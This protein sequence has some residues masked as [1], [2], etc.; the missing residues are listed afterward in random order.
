MERMGCRLGT[1][2]RRCRGFELGCE[3]W[4]RIPAAPVI[5]AHAGIQSKAKHADPTRAFELGC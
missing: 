1:G 2:M 5:P 4:G 3:G